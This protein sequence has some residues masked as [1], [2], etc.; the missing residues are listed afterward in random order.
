MYIPYYI[1]NEKEFKFLAYRSPYIIRDDEERYICSSTR[2]EA[3]FL[4][5]LI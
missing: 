5:P 1:Q 4:A 3:G 2:P